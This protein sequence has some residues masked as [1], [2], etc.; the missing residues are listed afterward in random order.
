MSKKKNKNKKKSTSKKVVPQKEKEQYESIHADEKPKAPSSLSGVNDFWFNKKLHLG[1]IFL[2]S[3]GIYLNTFSHEYAVDDS[4]VILRNNYTKKGLKGM[5]GIWSEDTF[6]GFFGKKKNLVAGGRYRPL[7]VATFALE[8]ELFGTPITDQQGNTILDKD[9]D[10]NYTG[11]PFLSHLVNVLLYAILCMV[12]YL[13]LLQMFNPEEDQDNIKGYFIA[14]AGALLYAAH[15][16]H[17]EA[18]ANIKGRDEIMVLL[19]GILATYWTL[20]AAITDNKS[21]WIA[22]ILAFIFAI[23]SKENAITFLAII[24][25]AIYFFTKDHEEK[26]PQILTYT[27]PFFVLTLFFW[28]G[29]RGVILGEAAAVTTAPAIELMNDP[30]LKLENGNY[31][32]YTSSE[33]IATVMHT[34]LDYIKLLIYPGTLTNDYYPKHIRTNEDIIPTF[35]SAWVLLSLIVHL[36]MAGF[37]IL[38]I[39]RKKPY[40]FFLLFYAATF[41]VVS[42]L[43]FP[44]GTNMAE[45]FMFLPSVGYS[46]L[47][48]MGLYYL[49]EKALYNRKSLQEAM[50]I[51]IVILVIVTG[52]CSYKTFDRNFAWKD[53]YTLFTTD[54]VNSP[55][56][57][58]LNNAVSGVLQDKSRSRQYQNDIYK[59]KEIL[60]RSLNHSVTA[61]NLHPTYNNAWLLQGN[62]NVLLG[63]INEKIGASTTTPASKQANFQTALKYYDQAVVC[64]K[65]VQQLRPNH[66]DVQRNLGVVH[67]DKG[68]LLGQYM[69]QNKA[70]VN[71][72]QESLKYRANDTETLRLLGVANGMQGV[73]FQ[74]QALKNP[75]NQGNLLEKATQFHLKAIEYF[76]KALEI[77]PNNVPIIYNLEIAYSVL[78]LPEKAA[79]YKAQRIKLDP[80]YDP[81]KAQE[82]KAA[83]I[84]PVTDDRKAPE[85]EETPKK[86]PTK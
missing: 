42:N 83:G 32:S 55:N 29:I 62:A 54:I 68:K 11:S 53:D 45:R 3:M 70:S 49:I 16:I 85:E 60:E 69:G 44:I 27:A 66:P 1:L 24:P 77:D 48:A 37:T 61:T 86:L 23:F 57:A 75:A 9:G 84:A 56:S 22:G 36:A 71:A 39:L 74:D 65:R 14:L 21:Y 28:F 43:I 18:V 41:S 15:P 72:L 50:Q 76:N 2:L 26:V 82:P 51:P 38:G 58:K 63:N 10:V 30:F 67:R 31:V 46:A 79:E 13:M 47:C 7:S 34:W 40:A 6:T 52:L 8:L 20:K 73:Q 19:G 59:Q 78:N 80:T 17:T 12:L 25:A 4:I 5:S 64:Y 35:Q 81:R 33:R